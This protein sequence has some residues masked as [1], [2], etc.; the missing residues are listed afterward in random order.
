[1]Q[2]EHA[3]RPVDGQIDVVDGHHHQQSLRGQ[4]LEQP[5]QRHLVMQIQPR[6]GFV[7]QQH[8]PGRI[9]AWPQLQQGAGDQ[10]PLLLPPGQSAEVPCQQRRQFQGVAHIR[11]RLRL[12]IGAPLLQPQAQ[13]LEH[14]D[15]EQLGL[16]L[17]QH[18]AP[19]C[20]LGPAQGRD[21]LSPQQDGAIGGQQA[22]QCPEQGGLAA[23]VGAEQGHQL[24]AGPGEIQGGEA[25][26]DGQGAGLQPPGGGISG[27]HRHLASAADR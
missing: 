8:P 16:A 26:G 17:G 5:Q 24:T 25:M 11:H 15:V 3:I 14:R 6:Q 20:K 4:L 1:M 27:T 22:R 19:R 21:G 18:G 23:A 10:H 12:G 7:Q 9:E 13:H 2:A